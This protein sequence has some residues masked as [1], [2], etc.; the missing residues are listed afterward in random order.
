MPQTNADVVRRLYEAG[1]AVG[2]EGVLEFFDPEIEF[3]LT[4]V[5]PDQRAGRGR[6]AFTK[7]ASAYTDTFEEWHVDLVELI[8]IDADRVLA[9][10]RDGGR[11]KGSDREIY[12]DFAHLWT[13]REGRLVRW[14]GFTDKT[15]ALEAAAEAK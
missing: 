13:L 9:V 1:D 5:S 14:A 3:D 10:V 12:N 15:R 6:D 2:F 8:E 4:D 7:A 11:L